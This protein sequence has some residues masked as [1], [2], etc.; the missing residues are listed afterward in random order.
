MCTNIACFPAP[1]NNKR[2]TLEWGNVGSISIY[3]SA[4]ADLC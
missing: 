4:L 2:E 3:G 1:R